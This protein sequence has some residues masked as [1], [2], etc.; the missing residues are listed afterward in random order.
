VKKMSKCLG[1]RVD[2]NIKSD[3]DELIEE[4]YGHQRNKCGKSVAKWMKLELAIEGHD[5]YQNDPDVLELL[6]LVS[7]KLSTYSR[8]VSKSTN[9][10]RKV[11]E[12]ARDFEVINKKIDNIAEKVKVKGGSSNKRT[13]GLADFKRQFKAEYGEFK[14]VSKRDLVRFVTNNYDVH[15]SRAIQNRI[16]YLLAHEV[17]E[18]SAPNVFNVKI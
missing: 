7:A 13:G 17:L 5:S 3:Y 1:Y 12:I 9:I 18:L 14:Q 4:K 10:E 2:D 11:D 16:N 8:N 15:D 6:N